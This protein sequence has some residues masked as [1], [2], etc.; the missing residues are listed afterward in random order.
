MAFSEP[1]ET[2]Y[3]KSGEVN[4]AY[5]VV[6]EGPPDLVYVPGWVSNVELNWE[7]PSYARFLTRLASFSRLIVF[8]K[9][10]TGLSDR[11]PVD[12]LP[13]LEQR[14]DDVRA[15]M[16][17][18]GSDRATLFGVSEGGPMCALF[19]AT[20]PERTTSLVVYGSYARRSPGG[21]EYPWGRSRQEQEAFLR[22]IETGWGGPVAL[23]PRAP[24]AMGDESFVRWWS[25]YLRQSASPQAVLAL[26]RMN[27]E[28]DVREVLPTIQ[29]PTLVVH[30]RGD[31]IMYTEEARYMAERIPN[32]RLALLP[33][34]DHLPWVADQDAI[35]DEIEE[36][37]TGV[38]PVHEPDR[39]LATVLFTDIVGSTER[40]AELG[41]RRWRGLLE[42]H[43]GAVRR[44]LGRHRGREIDTAGDGFLA[45]FDGP[46]RGIRCAV[47]IRG[48]IR[49][50]DLDVRAGVHTGEVE[51]MGENI[52]GIG[53]HIAARVMAAAAP[54]EVVVSSTVKDLVAGSGIGFEDRGV[55]ALKGVPGEWRL[56]RVAGT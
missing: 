22:E 14:M 47:A 5:Q 1:P 20:Y 41:D 45:T 55:Q 19:A 34:D 4:I 32:A 51:L 16:D 29:V 39:V 17:A 27:Y 30:R 36:F 9:R 37:V 35:L 23:A 50:M 7:E 26:T 18:A 43:H 49:G 31:R 21:E 15:V 56:F 38:R 10:G 28:V 24:S 42:Q 25:G 6:G 12:H 54:G 13:T 33:G 3:A 40:A 48:A 44:E 8:D 2:R 11:V 46:A 52:G 53:V